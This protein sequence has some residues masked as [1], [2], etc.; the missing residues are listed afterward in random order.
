MKLFEVKKEYK[1]FVDLDG[2]MADLDA[3]VL[4]LT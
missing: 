1:L 2:V 3:H 4:D